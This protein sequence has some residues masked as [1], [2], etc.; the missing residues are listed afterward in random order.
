MDIQEPDICP[1]CG[2][3]FICSKS[4]KCWCFEVN[5]PQNLFEKIQDQYD[6]CLC[7]DCIK[8]LIFINS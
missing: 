7:P 3:T 5:I 4:G 8:E 1:K 6:S 2:K